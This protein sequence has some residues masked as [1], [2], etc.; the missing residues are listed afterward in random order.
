[1]A[2]VVHRGEYVV[3]KP[4]MD[5]PVVADAVTT[6]EAIRRQHIIPSR[7]PGYADGGYTSPAPHSSPRTTQSA[8]LAAAVRELH[9]VSRAMRNLKAYVVY[10]DLER[11]SD[12]ITNARQP[13]TR[14]S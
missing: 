13:F 1:V 2:G 11:A 12:T 8:D 10:Q 14:N 9:G 5:M 7:H 3:P 6:I 4:I